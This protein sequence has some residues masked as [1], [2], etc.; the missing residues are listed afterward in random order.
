MI[1]DPR[2]GDAM[3]GNPLLTDPPRLLREAGLD[4]IGGE[5][6]LTT[7][8]EVRPE[9][10]RI[11]NAGAEG[12]VLNAVWFLRSNAMVGAAE[13]AG[14][15]VALWTLPEEDAASAVGFG[16]S[17][18]ALDEMGIDHEVIFGP[19]DEKKAQMVSWARAAHAYTI[20]K[21]SRYGQVGG[22]CL[23]MIPTDVDNN[24]VRRIFGIDYDHMEQWGL[25]HRAQA[26]PD[27]EALPLVQKWKQ[28]FRTVQVTDD[29]MVRS[30]K[31]YLAGRA[32]AQERRWDAFGVKCQFEFIDN[33]IAPCLPIGMWNEEGTV[34]SC[35]SDQ[36]AAITMMAL[37]ALSDE[38]V[39]FSDVSHVYFDEGVVRLL[40]CGVAAPSY[41]GGPS[42]VDLMPCPEVQGT[43]DERTGEH[44]CKGGAC[45]GMLVA[46]G[47]GTLARFGR[48]SGEYVL[49]LTRCEI[50]DHAHS[51]D[52]LFGLGKSWPFAYLKPEQPMDTFLKNLR[53]HHICLARGDWTTDMSILSRMW[54][55]PVL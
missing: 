39:M 46:P 11:R 5:K 15:P 40:N 35:E 19:W 14:L 54:G 3:E 45:T 9:A 12:L 25:I 43:L 16:V 6:M 22:R 50:V 29:V 13:A 18:G 8:D 2:L 20:L 44:L 37:N 32:V 53:A 17:H 49:H 55:I 1:G 23:E 7:E 41:A 42:N 47:P 52:I 21:G 28:Q 34:V 10:V 24:Q 36:N 27:E 30:A 4:V 26:V 38:P 48:V 33:Y 51:E 31:V